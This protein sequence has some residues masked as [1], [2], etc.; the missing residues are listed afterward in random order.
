MA[1]TTIINHPENDNDNQ[2]V[3]SN[4]TSKTGKIFR[5]KFDENVIDVMNHFAC[6]HR[7]DHRKDFKE[8][9]SSQSVN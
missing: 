8:A 7:Y 3:V 4:A 6:V 2:S 1:D 9:Q 5:F